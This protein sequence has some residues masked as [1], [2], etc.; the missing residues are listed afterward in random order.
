MA[1]IFPIAAFTWA[2]LRLEVSMDLHVTFMC[3]VQLAAAWAEMGKS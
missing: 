1:W 2:T 3:V